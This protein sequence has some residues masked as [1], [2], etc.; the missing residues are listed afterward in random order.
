MLYESLMISASCWNSSLTVFS[1][2]TYLS[3]VIATA[4]YS[5]WLSSRSC[6]VVS[7]CIRVT[8][9]YWLQRHYRLLHCGTHRADISFTIIS[10]LVT[11]QQ[12]IRWS[13]SDA[14]EIGRDQ[15]SSILQ[16]RLSTSQLIFPLRRIE[17]LRYVLQPSTAYRES[18]LLPSRI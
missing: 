12:P 7:A 3:P 18:S 8:Y 17:N 2:A 6:T 16:Q 14:I 9:V 10:N 13:A 5:N 11:R 15:R 1:F 4:S